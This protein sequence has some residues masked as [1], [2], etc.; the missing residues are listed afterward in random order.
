MVR[1]VNK[2]SFHAFSDPAYEKLIMS[3]WF[4]IKPTG[5]FVSRQLLK[6]IAR[7]AESAN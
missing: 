7:R 1:L 2:E 6:A 3:F 5:A 4:F